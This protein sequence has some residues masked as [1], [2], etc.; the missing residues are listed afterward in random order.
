M[1]IILKDIGKRF[2]TEWVFRKVNLNLQSNNAYVILGA[3]GSGKSTL[4]QVIAGYITPSEGKLTYVQSEKNISVEKISKHVSIASP[5]LNLFEKLTLVETIRF[6]AG[7]KPFII[8][9]KEMCERLGLHHARN[10]QL[11]YFSSG[12]KQRVK[13]GLAILS[14]SPLLLLDEP[15]SNLDHK[16]IDWYQSLINEHKAN[17]LVMVCSNQ[18]KDEFSFCNEKIDIGLYKN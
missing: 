13:L 14:S 4:M 3:N 7:F 6:Q 1:E 16:A 9:E 2:N 17:R 15:V 18:Q 5:Y 10:K 8:P 12:M 11:R